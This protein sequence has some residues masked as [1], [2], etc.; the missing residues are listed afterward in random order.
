VRGLGLA[1]VSGATASA[2]FTTI[3]PPII[4]PTACIGVSYLKPII[5]RDR[6]GFYHFGLA[7][8]DQGVTAGKRARQKLEELFLET[9]QKSGKPKAT[10]LLR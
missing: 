7:P 6:V 8:A 5:I 1:A 3:H 9:M 10:P 2:A 4:L